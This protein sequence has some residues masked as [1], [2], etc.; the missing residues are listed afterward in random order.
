MALARGYQTKPIEFNLPV[1][2][3]PLEL[4]YQAIT[5]FQVEKDSYDAMSQ[6]A[7]RSRDIDKP[8]LGEYSKYVQDLTENVTQA[9]ASGNVDYAMKSL[10]K[11]KTNVADLWKPGGLAYALEE[12]AITEAQE[13]AKI[14]EA[15]KDDPTGAGNLIWAL[16]RFKSG[17]QPLNYDY[18]TGKYNRVGQAELF[19][20]VDKE[21]ILL[22]LAKATDPDLTEQDIVSGNWIVRLKEKGVPEERIQG[23]FQSFLQRPEVQSQLEIDFFNKYGVDFNDLD[24]DFSKLDWQNLTPDDTA[25]L[26]FI[27]ASMKDVQD[28]LATTKGVYNKMDASEKQQYL[29]QLGFYKGGIDGE[30]GTLSKDAEQRYLSY[31]DKQVAQDLETLQTNPKSY[32][33]N[34]VAAEPS[35]QLFYNLFGKEYS[36]TLKANPFALENLKYSHKLSLQGNLFNLQNQYSQETYTNAAVTPSKAAPFNTTIEKLTGDAK[37]LEQ[38]GKNML[39]AIL[40]QPSMKAIF[41]A[42]P[43]GKDAASTMSQLIKIYEETKTAP[44]PVAA[45]ENKLDS[46]G[47]TMRFG[48]NAQNLH[49]AIATNGVDLKNA[50][51]MMEDGKEEFE[52]LSKLESSIVVETGVA[53]AWY[54]NMVQGKQANVFGKGFTVKLPENY[55][56]QQF[57]DAVNKA[58]NMTDEQL[59]KDPILKAF[60]R[61]G[62]GPAVKGANRNQAKD[63][64]QYLRNDA[65]TVINEKGLPK[66]GASFTLTSPDAR[67]AIGKANVALTQAF[68]ANKAGFADAI[69]G[70]NTKWTPVSGGNAK[71]VADIDMAGAKVALTSTLGKPM[72]QLTTVKN[73]VF[74]LEI[75]KSGNA[76]KIVEQAIQEELAIALN[77]GAED[78][79]MLFSSVARQ[80]HMNEADLGYSV[81]QVDNYNGKDP[82]ID[83]IT[84]ADGTPLPETYT[85]VKQVSL[86]DRTGNNYQFDIITWG[87]DNL[88]KWGVTANGV[89]MGPIQISN[90]QAGVGVTFDNN[91]SIGESAYSS[92]NDA[93][94][95]LEAVNQGMNIPVEQIIQKLP[96]GTPA[97]FGNMNTLNFNTSTQLSGSGSVIEELLGIEEED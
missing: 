67:A 92:Y 60:L 43:A 37:A 33:V 64:Q 29:K 57:V 17:Q 55:T 34:E 5:G 73:G 51:T 90:S 78:D 2:Q 23:L 72:L 65:Q 63:I 75:P 11:A 47:Y 97:Q 50:I 24:V 26:G 13:I 85:P 14:Q 87:E 56:K 22:D 32:F 41:G 76:R 86:A 39:G 95:A 80:L 70:N 27:T 93:L 58:A 74:Q 30:F 8:W 68:M 38:N 6:T 49:R 77:K 66:T 79:L 40:K 1:L 46:L 52:N 20:Y 9:F 48:T 28:N 96:K 35:R 62:F 36:R 44:D 45:F 10:R 4:Q 18:D 84:T 91:R 31:L 83:S 89:L 12:G 88:Q 21:K 42:I 19:N 53:D 25:K 82:E 61:P 3:A 69:T 7:P 16:K 71:K 81:I 94:N 59:A 15:R 54:D